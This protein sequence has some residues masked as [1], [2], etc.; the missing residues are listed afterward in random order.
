MTAFAPI[1][2]GS[3]AYVNVVWS[4]G[5]AGTVIDPTVLPVLMAFPVSSG[6]P[7]SPATPATWYPASWLIGSTSA[8]Y[9][10]QTIVGPGGVVMLTAGLEYDTWSLVQGAPETPMIFAGTLPVLGSA[11]LAALTGADGGSADGGNYPA[12]VIDGGSA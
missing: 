4:A 3:L 1:A 7:L 12:S 2:A 5:L 9:I 8:G 10:A 11:A 6:D